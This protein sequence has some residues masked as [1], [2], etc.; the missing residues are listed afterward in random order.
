MGLAMAAMTALPAR[1]APVRVR[2]PSG[3]L[4]G[5][6]AGDVLVFKGVPFAMPPVGPRRWQPSIPVQPWRGVRRALAYGPACAQV[7]TGTNSAISATSREDCLTLNLCVPARARPGSRL[8]VMVFF[9]GGGNRSGS[10]AGDPRIDP[11]YDGSQLARHGVIVVTANY[12]LGLFG[13][14]AHPELTAESP[15]HSSGNYALSDMLTALRWVRGQ[16]G[17]F[18]GDPRRVTAFGQSGGG[19]E[20]Q[21]ADD[22]AALA[23]TDPPR[24]PA[25]RQR[26]R[27]RDRRSQPCRCRTAGQRACL[28]TGGAAHRR[29]RRPARDAGRHAARRVRP[30][31]GPRTAAD[32]GPQL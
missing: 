12:R 19:V 31:T 9:H 28:G 23:R 5:A 1:A 8:P 32:A 26:A 29:D 13:F 20:H 15:H 25:E 17:A 4:Q 11:P 22:L 2:T 3:M 18:G 14:L 24:D 27:F 21:R 7:D 16:I 6:R 30:D 10:A